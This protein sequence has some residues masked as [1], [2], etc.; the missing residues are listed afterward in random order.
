MADVTTTGLGVES[1]SSGQVAEPLDKESEKSPRLNE[2][3][4]K[5]PFSEPHL[6]WFTVSVTDEDDVTKTLE[7]IEF[8][9]VIPHQGIAT[10]T[11]FEKKRSRGQL[12]FIGELPSWKM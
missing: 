9:H 8:P 12:F 10:D 3:S 5:V 2:K 11:L 4:G 7:R 6:V 1:V